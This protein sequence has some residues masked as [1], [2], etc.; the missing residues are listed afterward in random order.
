MNLTAKSSLVQT[1]LTNLAT[2]KLP[3]PISFKTSNL[4]IPTK[5]KEEEVEEEEE[6]S[7]SKEA[8]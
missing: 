2:P 4:S 3:D 8:L 1:S 5:K 7:E 6:E